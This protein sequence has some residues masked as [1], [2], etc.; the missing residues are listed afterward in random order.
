M[1]ETR[2]RNSHH[3]PSPP[4]FLYMKDPSNETGDDCH[5]LRGPGNLHHHQDPRNKAP[6]ME[7]LPMKA[8]VQMQASQEEEDQEKRSQEQEEGRER[9]VEKKKHFLNT[10][11]HHRLLLL[12]GM[13]LSTLSPPSQLSASLS[14]LENHFSSLLLV[15]YQS[16]SLLSNELQEEASFRIPHS[17]PPSLPPSCDCTANWRPSSGVLV[18]VDGHFWRTLK[19]RW[20]KG[21]EWAR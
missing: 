13:A 16:R 11:N 21:W 8:K 20:R 7:I 5:R 10:P 6:K 4:Y 3:I 12:K 15:Y 2:T 1:V 9:I 14:P 18:P 17:F 19:T